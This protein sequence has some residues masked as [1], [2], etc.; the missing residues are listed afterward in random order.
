MVLS[1]LV[2]SLT[3]VFSFLQNYY[4]IIYS[5]YIFVWGVFCAYVYITMIHWF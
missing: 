2:L 3:V 1:S 5:L 4:Y